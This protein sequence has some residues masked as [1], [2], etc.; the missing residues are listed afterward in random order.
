MDISSF[1]SALT[2]IKEHLTQ[3]FSRI[4]TGRASIAMLDSVRV[5]AYGSPMPLNQ[6]GSLTVEDARTI[7]VAPWDSSLLSAIEKGVQ[8]ADIGVTT[9]SSDGGVRIHFPELTQETR[10]KIVKSAKEKHEDARISVK[11]ERNKIMTTLET[12]K[13]N[14]ELGED[15][16][17]S[18]KE[19]IESLVQSINKEFDEMI[20]RKRD[21]I[22]TV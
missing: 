20:T 9:S 3:E 13:K 16:L 8:I 5:D 21:E 18:L 10:E 14:G 7:K 4:R 15:D 11:N 19:N 2:S 1:T 22:M 12:A 17:S 6:V